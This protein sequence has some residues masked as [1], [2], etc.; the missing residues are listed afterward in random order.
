M[1]ARANKYL[2]VAVDVKDHQNDGLVVVET[3][4]GVGVNQLGEVSQVAGAKLGTETSH[5][6]ETTAYLFTRRTLPPPNLAQ[7]KQ[8][9]RS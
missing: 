6:K 2:K 4:L 1:I 7:L 3:N 5:H 8:S 9:T